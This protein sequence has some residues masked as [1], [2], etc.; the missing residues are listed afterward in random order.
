[1][2]SVVEG[3]IMSSEASVQSV[4]CKWDLMKLQRIVRTS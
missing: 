3:K 1:M 4:F 2:V